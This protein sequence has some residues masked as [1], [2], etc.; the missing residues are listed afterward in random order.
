MSTLSG[1]FQRGGYHYRTIADVIALL[2]K[3]MQHAADVAIKCVLR[4]KARGKLDETATDNE[5]AGESERMARELAEQYGVDYEGVR[6]WSAALMQKGL[7]AVHVELGKLGVPLIDRK[8]GIGMHGR[9]LITVMPLAARGDPPPGPPP[10]PEKTGETATTDAGSS[11]SLSIEQGTGSDRTGPAIDP[12]ILTRARD[13]LPSVR[14]GK[15]VDAILV[16]GPELVTE[17][18]DAVVKHN[19]KPGNKRVDSWGFVLRALAAKKR[20]RDAEALAPPLPPPVPK[21]DLAAAARKAREEELKRTAD[22]D[23]RAARR[24]ARWLGLDGATRADIEAKVKA[25]NPGVR[26][27]NLLE[28]LCFEEMEK[29]E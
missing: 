7:H 24:K 23:I 28:S 20:E 29:R 9:R 2:P 5:L 6:G 21:P 25:E 26:W 27:A 11:S 16:Y 8:S 3:G 14:A 22:E 13:L 12:A 4:L 10:D 1:L 19:A 17:S 18:L 15:V